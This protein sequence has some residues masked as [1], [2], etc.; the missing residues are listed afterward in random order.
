VENKY[1]ENK[2][3]NRQVNKIKELV[4]LGYSDEEIAKGFE[5]DGEEN[6]AAGGT[7]WSNSDIEKIRFSFNFP[8]RKK[9]YSPIRIVVFFI[10]FFA[11]GIAALF[12][13]FVCNGGAG[14]SSQMSA[15]AWDCL[16]PY[17]VIYILV[18]VGIIVIGRRKK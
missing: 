3:A 8:Q 14:G 13:A 9:N 2:E 12:L 1:V 10:V 7:I 17:L 16:L 4:A 6:L 11:G 5:I 15:S 18:L